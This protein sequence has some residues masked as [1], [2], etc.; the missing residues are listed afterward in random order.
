MNNC[1]AS[2]AISVASF[3][4]GADLV[5]EAMQ[6]VKERIKEKV[7]AAA[8]NGGAGAVGKIGT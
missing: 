3:G 7:K 6:R 5:L 2:D 8:T 4:V 1:G